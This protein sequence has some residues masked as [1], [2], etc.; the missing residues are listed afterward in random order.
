MAGA[1]LAPGGMST[2]S[3]FSMHDTSL[4]QV[5][6]AERALPRAPMDEDAFRAFYERTARPLWAYLARCTGDPALADDLLQESYFRFYRAGVAFED[7]THRRNSL[8]R[9]ATNLAVDLGRHQ[10]RVRHTPLPE[11][12][13][14]GC[15]ADESSVA[16]RAGD[17][18]DLAR[19]M[20]QLKPDQR[21]M[22]WLAYV[23]GA[24]HAEIAEVL[25]LKA[26]SIKLLLFRARK[27]LAR[28][29]GSRP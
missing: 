17:R 22:L 12:D 6:A 11:D 28:I 20:A 18:T 8:F 1:R 14:S 15:L 3:T 19:A 4:Q 5:A 23:Q 25:G 13:E 26:A 29:L 24:S 7:E 10:R 9:I 21:S 27:R 16:E 2:S